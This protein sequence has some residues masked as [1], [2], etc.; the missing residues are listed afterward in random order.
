MTT[1]FSGL[2]FEPFFASLLRFKTNFMNH[3][4]MRKSIALA[5]RNYLIC[6]R[7]C[8]YYKCMVF[9][10]FFLHLISWISVWQTAWDECIWIYTPYQLN[11]IFVSMQRQTSNKAQTVW[12]MQSIQFRF[13]NSS[14]SWISFASAIAKLANKY[15]WERI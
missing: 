15:Q 2:W 5:M 4:T 12:N 9:I 3:L 10:W 13:V 6:S 14:D 11:A 1:I 7:S 8:W